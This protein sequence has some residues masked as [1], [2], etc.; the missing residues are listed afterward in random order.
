MIIF[1]YLDAEQLLVDTYK[2]LRISGGSFSGFA[3]SN[4]QQWRI[5]VRQL[6]SLIRLSEALAR[7]YCSDHV[8]IKHVKGR[9]ILFLNNF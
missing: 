7:L 8:E 6:E 3:G 5:T 9:N 1:S 2:Q 4:K